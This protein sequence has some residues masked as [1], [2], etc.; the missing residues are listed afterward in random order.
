[1]SGCKEN[2]GN[3]ADAVADAAPV[4][5]DADRVDRPGRVDSCPVAVLADKGA[6]L[7]FVAENAPPLLAARL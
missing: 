4:A 7:A 6:I 3:D 1:M 2:T 5:K